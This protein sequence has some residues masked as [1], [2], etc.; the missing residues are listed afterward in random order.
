MAEFNYEKSIKELENIVDKLE[1]S[2]VSIDEAFKLYEKGV[3]LSKKCSD[4]LEQQ[5][6]K[7]KEIGEKNGFSE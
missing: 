1:N 4:Y 2:S 6:N 7:M 5:E 3:E